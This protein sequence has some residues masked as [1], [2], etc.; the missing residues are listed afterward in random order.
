MATQQKKAI[1][2]KYS[3]KFRRAKCVYVT[4]FGGLDVHMDTRVRKMF[5]EAKLEYKVLKNRL[6]IRSLHEAG[7]TSLDSHL[8][9]VSSFIIGYDDPVIPA[10]ILRDFNKK[11]ELLRIKALLL[12]GKVFSAKDVEAIADLPSREVLL[13][14]LLGVLKAPM[15]K[16]VGTMQ[17]SLTKFVRT[18][19]AVKDNKKE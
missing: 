16:L 19:D 11:K 12:E 6:A 2:E 15:S 4:D 1:V 8:K 13:A 5:R 3:D 10:K 7:I 17:A 18:L 9:G 14:Q